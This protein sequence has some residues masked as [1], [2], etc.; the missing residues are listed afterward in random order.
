LE[1]R[2][3]EAPNV[4]NKAAVFIVVPILFALPVISSFQVDHTDRMQPTD[5]CI[6]K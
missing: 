4:V 3:M 6:L 1:E 2:S 5:K